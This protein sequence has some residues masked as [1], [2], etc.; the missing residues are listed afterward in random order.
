MKFDCSI[1]NIISSYWCP[2]CSNQKLCD[3]EDCIECFEKSFASHEKSKFWCNLNKDNPRQIFKGTNKKYL[4]NCDECKHN[5]ES[6][7]YPIVSKNNWCQYCY[8]HKLCNKE[9][10]YE[11]FEKS[12]AS[13]E[14]S[15]Y[16]SPKNKDNPRYIFKKVLVLYIYL[17]VHVIMNLQLI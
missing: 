9:Y 12:F 5:F 7:I 17:I 1:S 2:Y 3:N 10:C 8:N 15:K 4:F 16:W 13:H 11:C 6:S 14:K